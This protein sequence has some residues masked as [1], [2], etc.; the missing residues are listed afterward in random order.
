M[1]ENTSNFTTIRVKKDTKV[2]LNAIKNK[3]L[4]DLGENFSMDDIIE[5]LVNEHLG[6]KD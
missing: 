1:T 3:W 2:N 6:I 4:A 5:V